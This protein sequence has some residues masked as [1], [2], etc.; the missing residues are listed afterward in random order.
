MVET[1]LYKNEIS[2]R[3][4]IAGKISFME[5]AVDAFSKELAPIMKA[6]GIKEAQ[7]D[8][9]NRPELQHNQ[10]LTALIETVSILEIVMFVG[11]W[12]ATKILDELY[13]EVLKKGLMKFIQKAK[14]N[15]ALNTIETIEYR[16]VICSDHTRPI[17]VVRVLV[18]DEMTLGSIIKFM[19]YM[20][21]WADNWIT[22]NG[23]KGPIHCYT[24]IKG[25]CLLEPHAY[26]KMEDI[27]TISSIVHE[28]PHKS[29]DPR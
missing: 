18:D 7:D 12:T 4:Y 8:I 10:R 20:H 28:W 15:N 25:S 26:E 3:I 17:I 19:R 2:Y 13:G 24:I 22:S 1:E 27:P 6:H 11:A 9:A 23:A 16:S 21:G 14:K 29:Y 5:R